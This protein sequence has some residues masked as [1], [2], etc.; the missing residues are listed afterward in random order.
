MEEH[1]T[2]AA[3]PQ[4]GLPLAILKQQKRFLCCMW[5][6]NHV[7]HCDGP[8]LMITYGA[9]EEADRPAWAGTLPQRFVVSLEQEAPLER[10]SSPDSLPGGDRKAKKHKKKK[11]KHKE[12][13]EKRHKHGKDG[14]IGGGDSPAAAPPQRSPSPE[15]RRERKRHRQDKA[16]A[17]DTPAAAAPSPARSPSPEPRIA[18]APSIQVLL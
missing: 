2:N 1:S 17:A 16:T 13:K 4:V 9:Q 3:P 12:G 11:H 14:G 15:P 5:C 6:L 8:Y 10:A 7:D 18:K